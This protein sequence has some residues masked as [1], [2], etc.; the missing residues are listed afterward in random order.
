MGVDARDHLVKPLSQL[1]REY[2]AAGIEW[3]AVGDENYGEGSS[4]EH[5]AMEPRFMGGR[6][7]LARSFARIAEANLKKQ[8]VLPLTF[9]E[10]LD[11][12]KVRADDT[13]DITDWRLSR[14]GARCASCC[15]TPTAPP[16]SSPRPTRCPRSTSS[17]SERVR[18]STCR[19]AAISQ[20]PRVA[21]RDYRRP[22]N[23]STIPGK[24]S[25]NRSTSA[26]VDDQPTETRSERSASTPIAA[27]TGDGSSVSDEHDEPEC[28]ATPCWSSASRIGSASTPSTPRH[29]RF[30]ET[31][32]EPLDTRDE[33][34]DLPRR[35][36]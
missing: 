9:A 25:T 33:L 6:A 19:P 17:G 35:G 22:R 14:P 11:Y 12:D 8:G 30:G 32:A 28:T 21:S 36:R 10:R 23:R 34:D 29:S 31:A 13:V 16:T 4:R 26:S 7:V 3:I 1:A 18:L 15:T 20:K 5:A 24:T 27:S 2:K